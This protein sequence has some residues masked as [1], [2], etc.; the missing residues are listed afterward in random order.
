MKTSLSH[1]RLII[2][3][4]V[5]AVALRAG[6][7][8][9]IPI[10]AAARGGLVVQVGM[11]GPFTAERIAATMKK[12][13]MLI[14]VLD[15]DAA[16]V[17]ALR[18]E[19]VVLGIHGAAT[20]RA[21]DAKTLP[22]ID[23]TVNMLVLADAAGLADQEILRVLAPRGEAI[24]VRDSRRLAKPVPASS[25]EWTHFLRAPDNNAVSH[26]RAVG[27][28]R[29]IQWIAGPTYS[30]HHD[31]MASLSAMV[32]ANGRLFSIED[33][34]PPLSIRLPPDW[35]L[36]ARDAC[37]GVQLWEI[38]MKRW[39]RP[40]KIG[41]RSGPIQ[42]PRRLVAAGDRVYA[43]TELGGPLRCLNAADGQVVMT[44]A[45][46]EGV[47]EILLSDDTL[48]LV[49]ATDGK[50]VMALDA[51]S[52]A[53]HWR[54]QQDA[55]Q[56][57][58]LTVGHERLFLHNGK[59]VVAL[60]RADGAQVWQRPLP[61]VE[62]RPVWM[63][64]T[65]VYHQGVVL[66]AD[67]A[68]ELPEYWKKNAKLAQGLRKHGGP[69][70]LT[71]LA[72]DSG[73]EL[74]H[75]EASECFHGAPDVFVING[76]VWAAQGP[77]RYFYEP[78]RPFLEK[79]VG[80]DFYIETLTGRD[81]RTGKI[82]K[83]VEA[84]EAF[85]LAHHHRCYR[86]KATERFLILGR[87]GIDMIDLEGELSM[88]H[89][90]TRGI[91]QYGVMPANGLLYVPPHACACYNASK[92]NGFFTYS[93]SRTT[94][95]ETDAANRQR[96]VKGPAFEQRGRAIGADDWPTY[97]GDNA[98]SGQGVAAVADDPQPVW[99]RAL[100]SRLSA[101]ISADGKVFVC[102]VDRHQVMALDL[103]SGATCWTFTTGGRVDSPPTYWQGR[104]IFGSA[105][106]TVQ[107]LSAADGKLVWRYDAAPSQRMLV[108]REQ[109]ESPWPVPGSVLVR[110]NV[111]YTLA[112]RSSMIDG[113]VVFLALDA[114][115][116]EQR[117]RRLI[118]DRDPET[119][120]Q[121][122]DDQDSLHLSG[123]LYDIPAS[124]GDALFWRRTCLTPDGEYA[125]SIPPHLFSPGGL[126][127]DAWWHRYSMT[128]GNTFRDGP[129][130][131]VFTR[132]GLAPFGRLMVHAKDR[133]YSYG[134]VTYGRFRL[135]CSSKNPKDKKDTIWD[136]AR[137]P[138]LVSAMALVRAKVDGQRLLLAGPPSSAIGKLDVLQGKEGGLLVVVDA[139][140]GAFLSKK[141]TKVIPVFDGM[142]A[143]HGRI[144]LS[145]TS[146]AVMAFE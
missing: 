64:P 135:A 53:L 74:W 29:R 132:T 52:G 136:Q 56:P 44:Y 120:R 7:P 55:I 49:K 27:F 26:D 114:R 111:V 81:P 126:L 10:W 58:S 143:A 76:L 50:Q 95:W 32:T 129:G 13:A 134:E 12:R 42:L 54:A 115:T 87:T 40:D 118:Y 62:Q 117:I 65:V 3:A 1:L 123:L 20:V 124:V 142:C 141:T 89:N 128:Y 70:R 113:G 101:P 91:C 59:S 119:G 121:K 122:V 4:L 2:L 82:I 144:V 16:N 75:A 25:D 11:E 139:E 43:A 60:N 33:L 109:L 37:N 8:E 103:S 86:N 34:G 66:C 28:P 77:A 68:T 83:T 23:N 19:L 5:L 73:A 116:G 21:F 96:L 105:D 46:T 145:T 39:P 104:V 112:G 48:Y 14:Q 125:A 15:T 102:A 138:V 30:R 69:S 78:L 71:A 45:D 140:S 92:L 41:F 6:T 93:S 61:S 131:G 38:P 84:P 22:Y 108:V 85:T 9:N 90:W 57:A 133:V 72:A 100:G 137:C 63:S 146:G 18:A 36:I 80:S 79:E 130:G 106:G 110:D 51:R 127:D 24:F 98:R 47:E 94:G 107:C 97:R 99:S 35:H 31:K 88:R 67:R 17:H